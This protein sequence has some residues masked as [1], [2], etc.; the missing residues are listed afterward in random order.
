MWTFQF[1]SSRLSCLFLRTG[2]CFSVIQSCPTLC[3]PKA[4][5]MPGFPV[6]HHHPV[7]PSNHLVLCHPFY[8]C[9]Q[10]FPASGSFLMSLLF[11]S[12]VQG[13]GASASA[14]V[15]P[16]SIQDWF[17]LGFTGLMSLQSGRLPRVFSNT[18]VQ[19]H[20]VLQCSAFFML[21]LS[22]PY[23]TSHRFD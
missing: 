17:P 16:M 5:S 18:T 12:G 15:L 20:Q 8:S 2:C 6:F 14:S 23:M 4:G 19:E 13:I 3:N 22:H 11:M 9:L 10:S 7:M 21:Q 1:C